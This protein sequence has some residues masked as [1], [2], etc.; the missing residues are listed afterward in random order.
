MDA[1]IDSAANASEVKQE[2]V[3]STTSKGGKFE[4]VETSN[5][6]KEKVESLRAL[7]VSAKVKR[8]E[9]ER[10]IRTTFT[11]E[12]KGKFSRGTVPLIREAF[13]CRIMRKWSF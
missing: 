12:H 7:V 1:R 10:V 9:M 8:E 3:T 6:M 2:L 4:V 5:K 11:K 13:E